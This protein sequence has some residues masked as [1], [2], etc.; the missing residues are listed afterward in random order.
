MIKAADVRG[1]VSNLTR[2]NEQLTFSG[3]VSISTPLLSSTGGAWCSGSAGGYLGVRGDGVGGHAE[4]CSRQGVGPNLC[5]VQLD[6][7]PFGLFLQLLELFF[8]L[9][10][11]EGLVELLGILQPKATLAALRTFR[12]DRIT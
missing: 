7:L 9:L 2:Q 10:Q 8:A 1:C 12:N 3:R 5:R 4:L 6:L 11:N